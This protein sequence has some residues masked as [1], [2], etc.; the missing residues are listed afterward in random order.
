[1]DCQLTEI[2]S[3]FTEITIEYQKS[4][5]SFHWNLHWLSRYCRIQDLTDLWFLFLHVGEDVGEGEDEALVQAD[6]ELLHQQLE[7][8]DKA[9]SLRWN[10]TT[11]PAVK[12]V[13]SAL[14]S[15]HSMHFVA[16]GHAERP[17][18]KMMAKFQLTV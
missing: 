12:A 11:Q 3:Q 2:I 9:D 15:Q 4:S 16:H 1:M 18:N 5:L 13:T 17:Q 6:V 7:V 10:L 8:P 14:C